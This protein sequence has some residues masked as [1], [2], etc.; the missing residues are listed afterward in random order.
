LEYG[1]PAV[2]ERKRWWNI[3]FHFRPQSLV[4][5]SEYEKKSQKKLEPYSVEIQAS[6]RVRNKNRKR[7]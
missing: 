4:W 7:N 6:I 5:P 3:I 1:F 2:K